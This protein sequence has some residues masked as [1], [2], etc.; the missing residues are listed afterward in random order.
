M[1]DSAIR[2]RRLVG[3]F[4]LL[5]ASVWLMILIA[6]V[7]ALAQGD[8][9]IPALNWVTVLLPGCALVPGA[10][11]SIKLLRSQKIEQIN[12]LWVRSGIY[13][14]FGLL[15]GIVA[16]VELVQVQKGGG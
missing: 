4:V 16:F 3:K 12:D 1:D 7:V 6:V 13:G 9:E 10:Y 5:L 15:I 11:L 2:L 14:A 8:V